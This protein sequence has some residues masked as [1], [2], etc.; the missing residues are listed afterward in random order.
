MPDI[1]PVTAKR[2]APLTTIAGYVDEARRV[3]GKG[4]ACWPFIQTFGGPTTDGGKWALP[5]PQEVR[6]MTFL[7]L[8]HRATGILYFS[9][10]PQGG[11]T[12]RS[13]P[14]LNRE[15][16]QIARWLVADGE[17]AEAQSSHHAVHVRARWV[18][19]DC[20]VM[21]VNGSR[22]P[23]RTSLRVSRLDKT[24]LNAV[25]D[26]PGAHPVDGA[27]DESL[28]SLQVKVWTSGAGPVH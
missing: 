25:D 18:N 13:L 21:A 23:V 9:Y 24:L 27:W 15:V 22:A 17:E 8:A 6:C 11:E 16:E 3:H 10:W 5:T 26:G 19:G 2:D 4:P 14:N 28:D 12:W 1:Y 7:A 20:I